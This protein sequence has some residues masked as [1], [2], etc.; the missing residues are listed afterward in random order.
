M[1]QIL[2]FIFC[3][4]TITQACKRAQKLKQ[5]ENPEVLVEKVKQGIKGIV[6]SVSGNQMPSVDQ[7]KSGPKGFPTAVFF[8]EPTNISQITRHDYQPLYNTVLTKLISTVETDSTGAFTAAL[9]VGTYSVFVQVDKLFFANNFD[10]KN[11]ISLVTVEEGKLTEIKILVNH[12][13]AY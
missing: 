2:F 3:I 10:I 4:L 11:N 12:N 5:V 7:K 13:A 8:Y 6:Q 1:R 9:P